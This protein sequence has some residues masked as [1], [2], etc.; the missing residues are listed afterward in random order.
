MTIALGALLAFLAVITGA[1]GAHG[2][3][4]TLD[5]Y[6]LRIWHTAVTYQMTHAL[7][8]VLL[9]LFERQVGARFALAQG[10]FL[11]GILVF[12]GSLYLLALTGTRWLGAITPFGGAAFLVG[13]LAFAWA[14]WKASS[15][16]G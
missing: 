1:F 9:G 12:S 14:G 5:E 4:K 13:W 6:G 16:S 11:V 8:L 10:A 7:A 15:S 2:L 3:E